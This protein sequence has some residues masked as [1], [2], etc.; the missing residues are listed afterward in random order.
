MAKFS[1]PALTAGPPSRRNWYQELL[2]DPKCAGNEIRVQEAYET[3]RE[4]YFAKQVQVFSNADCNP[5]TTDQALIKHLGRQKME[6]QCAQNKDSFVEDDLD[7]QEVNCAVIWARPPAHVL[8]LVEKI[9][10]RLEALV[11]ID[12]HSIPPED[13]HLSVIELSHRHS[14]PELL[15][16]VKAIGASRIQTILNLASTL[17]T[18]PGLIAPQLSFD[19]MGVA[20]NFVPSGNTPYTYHHL[21]ADMHALAL[22]SGVSIDMCYTAPSAHCTLGRFVGNAFAENEEA[23][24]KFVKAV[25]DINRVLEIESEVWTV[26]EDDPLELQLG[27]IKFGRARGEQFKF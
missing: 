22:E 9:Q 1:F 27:Y 5:V 25:V 14:V 2:D 23:R 12:L 3:H 4:A 19:R 16:V 18:K 8:S 13:I 24:S 7:A 17:E 21:R 11:G 10:K 26:G 6:F 20:L 15:T